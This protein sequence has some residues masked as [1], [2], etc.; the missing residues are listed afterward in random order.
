[1]ALTSYNTLIILSPETYMV[2][3]IL[4]TKLCLPPVRHNLVLRSRLLRQ[5]DNS[6][7]LPLTLVS[8]PAGF[9]KST[10]VSQWINTSQLI[11]DPIK[12][13]A[14]LSLDEADDQPARFWEYLLAALEM[15]QGDSL[16]FETAHLLLQGQ[17]DPPV[18]PFLTEL[19]NKITALNA[20][21]L[22]VL[23]DFQ[24][25]HAPSIL[26]GITFLVEHLPPRMHILL[27][28]RSDPSLP[29][30]RWR[31]RGWLN[32]IRTADL[33]F[34]PEEAADYMQQ[35][36]ALALSKQ[37]IQALEERTE[38]WIAGLQMAGLSLRDRNPAAVSKFIREF[39]GQ[40]HLILDYLT[41]EVLHRQTQ[42]SQDFLLKTSILSQIC[43][44]LCHALI[45]GTPSP[46][47]SIPQ[48]GKYVHLLEQLEHANLFIIPLDHH[49]TWYRFHHLFADLLRV[50][51]KE[52]HPEWIPELHRRAA[53]WY[54]ANGFPFEAMQHALSADDVSLAT[55]LI[56]RTVRKPATWSTGNIARMLDIVNTL[57]SEVI[58]ARPWLRVYLSGILYVGGQPILADQ[59]LANVETSLPVLTGPAQEELALY[60]NAF[61]AFYAAT[62]G[63]NSTAIHRAEQVLSQVSEDDR[64]VYGHALAT[65]AQ[66][67]FTRGDV[68]QAN[69]LYRRAV[70]N[71]KRKNARFT[72]VTWSSNLADVL[73]MQGQLREA[74]QVCEKTVVY[75][76]QEGSP[77]SALGYTHTFQV[78]ILY[79][80]N[81]LEEA[82][83]ALLNGLRL[84]Q[85]DGVSPNFGRSHALLA[86]IQQVRGRSQD[87]SNSMEIAR[88]IAQRSQSRRYIER[89]AAHQ[90]RLWLLQGEKHRA[91]QWAKSWLG[92]GPEQYPDQSGLGY[93]CEFETL[94]LALV[95]LSDQ[96]LPE[97]ADI[98]API[99]ISA[100][101]AGRT[102]TLIEALAIQSLVFQE[103]AAE[104]TAAQQ[105]LLRALQL[106][107]PE[108]YLRT[109]LN[110]GQPMAALLRS[111]PC[112]SRSIQ[113]YRDLILR[114][115]VTNEGLQVQDSEPQSAVLAEK[116]T[117]RELEILRLIAA[118]LSNGQ[119]AEKLYLTLN[120]IRAHSTHIFGK[121]DV[122]H[123]TE[124][125]AR[126]RE[127]GLIK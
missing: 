17:P 20:E 62:L 28:T 84:M 116:L 61:R 107:E 124:A 5:L 51:L 30:G 18:Q 92:S 10:L 109:F 23:D 74:A 71:Q 104:K 22:L 85:Q 60:T 53:R 112:S 76:S 27:L 1:M 68:A 127:L 100:E 2:S 4:N 70:E 91:G 8:A 67:A 3:T 25:I 87:A 15:N 58:A 94:T 93:L 120:T 37:D 98:L 13:I 35:V 80:W 111:L 65:L 90:A 77:G 38:G 113:V 59:M 47:S 83:E 102:G 6:L 43:P 12:H 99:L 119:I 95:L 108:H 16:R 118:G 97:A 115:F 48:E 49:R 55:D 40:H 50:R 33:R 89:V 123:R 86:M 32:E 21:R 96:H 11:S 36:Q 64:R 72:A 52:Q 106:A 79:E 78:A 31:I 45:D 63:D 114:Q 24:T 34:T 57:P 122:H 66:A 105:A 26:E 9:G 42:S 19:I 29:L 14:W 125:V 73:T 88:Q 126:A 101:Q 46:D 39:T 41:D 44:G 7:T 56:E 81:R 121:L 54:E 82:E 69:Q 75:G 103:Q 117:E 110:L